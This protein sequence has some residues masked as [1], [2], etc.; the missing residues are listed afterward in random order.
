MIIKENREKFIEKLKL[1]SNVNNFI[2]AKSLFSL[3]N[4]SKNFLEIVANSV[5]N[6]ILYEIEL[7]EKMPEIVKIFTSVLL[8]PAW[9][10]FKNMDSIDL[11]SEDFKICLNV[12]KKALSGKLK[13]SE[14]DVVEFYKVDRIPFWAGN[15][16]PCCVID[17][18]AFYDVCL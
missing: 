1:S 5:L 11:N 8:F 14:F 15:I 2:F 17:D 13:N 7:N 16:K 3:R 4:Y 9:K 12:A 18:Y 10:N 6:K